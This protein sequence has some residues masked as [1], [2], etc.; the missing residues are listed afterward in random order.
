MQGTAPH[1]QIL[2]LIRALPAV[3][4]QN[5]LLRLRDTDLA[6][7]MLYM[8]EDQRKAVLAPAGPAKSARVREA[9]ARLE[10]T[11]IRYDQYEQTALA[12][13]QVLR[14]GAPGTAPE[15]DTARGSYYRP[16]RVTGKNPPSSR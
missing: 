4:V 3:E 11:R 10:H 12:V 5:R 13:V 9:L 14:N 15:G 16:T 1:Q 6:L 8:V 7:A 2:D